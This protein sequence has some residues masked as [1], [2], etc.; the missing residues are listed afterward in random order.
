MRRGEQAF[1]PHEQGEVMS[2]RKIWFITGAGRGMGLDFTRAALAGAA[3]RRVGYGSPSQFSR[4]YG[5]FFGNAPARDIQR[6]R[7]GDLSAGDTDV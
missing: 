7:A 1:L 3:G 2:D 6:L 4:E 5:R